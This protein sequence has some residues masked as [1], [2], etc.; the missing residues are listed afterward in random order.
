MTPAQIRLVQQS[1]ALVARDAE[2]AARSFYAGLFAADP[3]LRGLFRGDLKEQGRKLMG[4][5]GMVVAGL[6]RLETLVP[7]VEDLGRRHAHYG[8]RDAHYQVVGETLINTLADALGPRFTAEVR[9]AWAAAYAVL[10]TTMMRAAS[11]ELRL[12]TASA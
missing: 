8:V 12:H 2:G 6:S 10:A 5:I 3:G 4:M 1:F 11:G 7:A 9:E